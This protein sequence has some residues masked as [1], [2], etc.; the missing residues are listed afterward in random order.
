MT[1]LKSKV[2]M[3]IEN[4]V[5]QTLVYS[6]SEGWVFSEYTQ[7]FSEYARSVL[8]T[9]SQ[10]IIALMMKYGVYFSLGL[11]QGECQ[12]CPLGGQSWG[13]QSWVHQSSGLPTP[14]IKGFPYFNFLGEAQCKKTPCILIQSRAERR[15]LPTRP[16]NLFHQ[17][18]FA[19]RLN[20][21]LKGTF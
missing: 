14:T 2:H 4:C 15:S 19:D 8:W 20:L 21:S 12:D 17:P 3:N 9:F 1:W 16:N 11:P 13:G 5:L 6:A 18:C 7:V 10:C